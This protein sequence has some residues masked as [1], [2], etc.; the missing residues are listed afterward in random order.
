MGYNCSFKLKNFTKGDFGAS[1]IYLDNN[2][3]T[4][5]ESAVFLPILEQMESVGQSGFVDISQS[6]CRIN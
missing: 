2:N 6:K 3:L 4:R 5:F 1:L